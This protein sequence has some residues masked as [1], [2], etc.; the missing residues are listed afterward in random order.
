MRRNKAYLITFFLPLLSILFWGSII[1]AQAIEEKMVTMEQKVKTYLRTGGYNESRSKI[2][3]YQK[4][5]LHEPIPKGNEFQIYDYQNLIFYRVFPKDQIYFS[6]TLNPGE[7]TRAYRIGILP[8]LQNASIPIQKIKLKNYIFNGQATTLFIV[9]GEIPGK[10]KPSY[11]YSF[12]WE[13]QKEPHFPIRMVD[14]HRD[15]STMIIEYLNIQQK[16]V[17]L[18]LFKPPNQYLH[19]NPY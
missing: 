8:N 17:D 7:V 11:H 6:H 1:Y 9:G 12:L 4:W 14:T 3:R 18:S 10:S 15:G 2:T 13:S 19:L 5:I 16:E